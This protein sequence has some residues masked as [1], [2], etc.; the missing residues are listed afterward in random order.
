MKHH[1]L[2]LKSMLTALFLT[3]LSVNL[4]LFSP[5][6]LLAGDSSAVKSAYSEYVKAYD[7]FKQ[8]VDQNLSD[9]TIRIYTEKYKNAKEK[10]EKLLKDS[11]LGAQE[12]QSRAENQGQAKSADE[13]PI[14]T[15]ESLQDIIKPLHQPGA[16]N[17]VDE[18]IAKLEKFIGSSTNREE[19]NKAKI[20]LADAYAKYKKDYNK[21]VTLLSEVKN[22]IKSGPYYDTATRA[23]ARAQFE[24]FKAKL[25]GTITENRSAAQKLKE[26]YN[27]TSWTNP[28]KKIK[29]WVVYT[30]SLFDYRK[31]SATYHSYTENGEKKNG[32]VSYEFLSDITG[33]R[34]EFGLND[35]FDN[36]CIQSGEALAQ[37]TLITENNPAWYARW[38]MLNQAK[39]S[40]DLTYFIFEQDAYGKSML[41]L[42]LK[43]A[44][45]GVQIRFLI[46]ARGSKSVTR[47]FLG[48]D[49]LQELVQYPNVKIKVYNPVLQA[50]PL[51]IEDLRNVLGSSHQKIIV[52]DGI[53][54]IT[55]GRNISLNYFADPRDNSTVF[56]DT[57]VF[58]KGEAIA[59]Q[60]RDTFLEE[61]NSLGNFEIDEDVINIIKRDKELL[62][63]EKSMDSWINGRGL[64]SAPEIKKLN[65][66][67]GTYKSMVNYGSFKPFENSE[68]IPVKL[69]GKG[70]YTKDSNE[71]TDTLVAFIEAA[72]SEIIIQ[73]PYVILTEKARG[74]L[75][76][77]SA[78]GVKIIIHTNS[79]VSTDSILTQAFFLEDWKN[80][81][82]ETPNARVFVF[83]GANK[84][85][86]KVFM[87]DGQISIVGT[88]NM[89]YMSEQINA[90]NICAIKSAEFTKE[91]RARTMK[92]IAISK[93]YKIEVLPDGSIKEIVGPGSFSS[94][95][96]MTIL[97][98]LMQF[99]ILKPLI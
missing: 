53:Y 3:F 23:L 18:A 54:S 9:E 82:K 74:A 21:S 98:I 68:L 95:K 37:A 73:N 62:L 87:F 46:D 86:A 71:I 8:A 52:V 55:G 96:T 58:L 66:E 32:Y 97:K 69:F 67:L 35:T 34:P 76:R 31:A 16:A 14:Q 64:V 50:I 42:L 28:F 7:E 56:R 19:V 20:E 41:G 81:L 93:E 2:N 94:K 90:E 45:E 11:K 77:A 91:C 48:Q 51:A 26:E 39:Q 17:H 63:A 22:D 44:R 99:K 60:M 75:S 40:I 29:N 10:Y 79:P 85:H 89:D 13:L 4:L 72:S 47:T 65:E 33:K 12:N 49:Y 59:G 36:F 6:A 1:R 24:Q 5:A 70:N 27:N 57:D 80:F 15:A 88:Y 43:K 78:R 84:L 38:Y 92:D 30:K 83:A 61:F 25:R